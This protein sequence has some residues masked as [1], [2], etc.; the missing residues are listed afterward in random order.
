MYFVHV[1]RL[2]WVYLWIRWIHTRVF[3][4][5]WDRFLHN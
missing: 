1:Q 2:D 5:F 4:I 3:F